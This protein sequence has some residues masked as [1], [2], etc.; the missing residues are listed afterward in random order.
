MDA[1]VAEK[2]SQAEALA[3]PFS[4][5]KQK[6]VIIIRPCEQFP[7]GAKIVWCAGHLFEIKSPHELNGQWK[8]WSLDH[9]PML[10]DQFQY[11]MVRGRAKRFQSIKTV[12]RDPSVRTIIAAGDPG[13]E[14]ELI[15]QLVVRM[16]GVKKPMKRLWTQSLTPQA[17]KDA[18]SNLLDIEATRPLYEE[19]LARSYADWLVGMNTSRAYTLLLRQQQQ[20]REVYATG[21]V[22]TPTLA[23]IVQRE[24]AIQA[25]TEE[26]FYEVIG[27]FDV[28]GNVYEGTLQ[29]EGGTRFVSKEEAEKHANEAVNQPSQITSAT[30]E[31]KQLQP[32][33]LHSLSSLQ[34]LAN[35]RYKYGAKK[36]LQ[37]LQKL[38]ERSYI[39]YPRTDS[40]FVTAAEAATFP[41]ILK[42]LGQQQTFADLL[43]HTTRSIATDRRYVNAK[44]V[45]DHH[46]ILPTEKMPKMD[47][48]GK[49][50]AAMYDLVVRSFIAAHC[51]PA[52]YSHRNITTLCA[53]RTFL[54]KSKQLLEPGWR[55]V[56]FAEETPSS[57]P[58]PDVIEGMTGISRKMNVKEGKTEPPKRYTEGDLITAMKNA[59]QAI[60][61]KQLGRVLK[62]ASGIGE[63]ST[64]SAIIER[65]KALEY[66]TLQKHR[67]VPTEKAHVLINCI[68]DTVLASPELT[69]RWEKRLKEIGSGKASSEQFIM[70]SRKFAS[71]LVTD[72]V[73][74]SSGWIVQPLEQKQN[75]SPPRTRQTQL[76]SKEPLGS[77]PTCGGNVVDKGKLYGC[78]QF[79]TTKCPFTL[80]KTILGKSIT[81]AAVKKLLTNGKSSLIKGFKGKS[82]FDAYLVWKDREKGSLGFEFAKPKRSSKQTTKKE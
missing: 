31:T 50:E 2:A 9:L 60:E 30:H 57:K 10:P 23:L 55:K 28:E 4:H 63:E 66:I 26:L 69:A 12:L 73:Q 79:S 47:R 3:A 77:C 78:D 81:A 62:E 20:A 54:S 56:L 59:G 24:K 1:I 37:L 7:Q 35:K 49:D 40:P 48:L 29:R 44:K 41:E 17:V 51:A 15:V 61:D 36:T 45:T 39:S 18:F 27:T 14:G 11:K 8:R 65:L 71:K 25:F 46:A 43:I 74:A 72:A 22:Q 80:S 42:K 76:S 21:R 64:R 38:Y 68:G 32:P 82:S 5:Q 53:E 16:T 13:R 67:I 19:A 34:A 58:L 75:A 52:K 6:D 70:Q 33:N